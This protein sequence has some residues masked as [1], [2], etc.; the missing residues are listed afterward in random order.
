[1]PLAKRLRGSLSSHLFSTIGSGSPSY[2]YRLFEERAVVRI[3]IRDGI[4]TIEVQG[5]SIVTI[6][7]IAKQFG[8]TQT[9]HESS[10]DFPSRKRVQI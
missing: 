3:G 2:L 1:M 10:T 8:T 4:V 9:A 5:A 6:V 7:R